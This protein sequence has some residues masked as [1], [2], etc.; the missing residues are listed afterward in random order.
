VNAIS[1]GAAPTPGYNT[2]L[3]MKR[4]RRDQLLNCRIQAGVYSQAPEGP[5]TSS[6]KIFILKETHGFQET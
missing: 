4:E 5:N 3:V 1:P 6:G 2:A